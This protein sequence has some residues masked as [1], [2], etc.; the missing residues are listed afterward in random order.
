MSFIYPRLVLAR[1]LLSDDGVIFISID[2]NE[3]ANLKLICDELFGED[4]FITN[5]V[6]QKK[7]GASDAKGLA[8]ITESIL[9]YVKYNGE[10]N[11]EKIFA[12]NS[13]SYDLNRYSLEDEYVETRGR[14]YTD[15]LD[16]GGLQYSDAMNYG[17]QAPDGTILFPNGRTEF[18]N[19]GWTWKWSR[20]KVKW[21]IENGFIVIE[22]SSRKLSGWAVKYKNYVNVDNE[23]MPYNRSAAYKNLILGIIGSSTELNDLL[24]G[25]YFKNPKPSQLIYTLLTYIKDTDIVLDFFSGSATTAQAVMRL[26]AI[27]GRRRK[28]ILVQSPEKIETSTAAYKAGYKTIDEIGRARIISAANRIKE[29]TGANIDYGFKLYKLK[30]VTGKT[31]DNLQKFSQDTLFSEDMVNLFTTEKSNGKASILLTY[32]ARDGYGLTCA[33]IPYRLNTY[34]ADKLEDSLYIIEQG[35]TSDDVVALIKKLECRELDINR[36]VLYSYSIEFNVLQELKKN[37]SNLQNNKHVELIE[38]Y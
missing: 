10:N 3:E 22:P 25:N 32:L 14:Y 27:D 33:T 12:T 18:F 28:Y 4:N 24:G 15:N 8:T 11:L 17:I 2:E 19:D 35:L 29:E 9:T 13:D 7:T 36:V 16:R 38:R 21:G 23:G 6:W 31:L 5:I 30:S 37:L 1:T 26:N 20:E 34:I